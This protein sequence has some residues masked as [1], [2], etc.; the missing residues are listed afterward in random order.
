MSHFAQI[1]YHA[2]GILLNFGDM[3]E[4]KEPDFVFSTD[5]SQVNDKHFYRWCVHLI[6]LDGEGSFVFN[7]RCW[8]ICRNDIAILILPDKVCNLA[9]HPDLRIEFFA[10]PLNFLNAQLPANNF[11]IGGGI[12]LYNNPIIPVCEEDAR[13]FTNDIH[14]L[15]DRMADTSHLF[16]RELMGSLCRTMMYDLFDFH[17]KYYGAQASTDRRSFIVKEL[18][19]LLQTGISRTEREVAYYANRLHV[20][21]KYL[22]DTVRRTTGSN[23]TSFIDH[24]TVPML[25]GFLED[26]RLSLTQ[27]A[28]MMNFASLSYFSRYVSKH[29]G[30]SPSQY[31]LGLQPDKK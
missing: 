31:R 16:Y 9:P 17:A 1:V 13:K 26:E 18:M 15:R 11:G 29:L 3:N 24:Y 25:K 30:M 12:T 20:T 6:C 4:N 10:A 14:R 21:P 7:D 19:K 22:S 5:F 8:H 2:I 28:E 23:V 27:I